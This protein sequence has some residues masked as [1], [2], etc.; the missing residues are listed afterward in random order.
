MWLRYAK[1][2]LRSFFARNDELLKIHAI[3][4]I[5]TQIYTKNSQNSQI[6]KIKAKNSR[7]IQAKI[8]K[9]HLKLTTSPLPRW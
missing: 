9:I 2:H 4:W 5:F 1:T 6:F 8:H 3:L 7:Q